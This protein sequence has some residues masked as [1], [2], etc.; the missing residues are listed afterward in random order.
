MRIGVT[1]MMTDTAARTIGPG[2]LAA[3]V[4]G[5]GFDGLYLPEHTH[6][7]VSRATPAPMGEPLP[8]AYWHTLDPF[9]ALTAAAAATSTIRLGTGVCLIAERDPIITAKTVAS[10]DLISGGRV[11]LGI[12]FGWNVEEMADHGV[13]FRDRRQVTRERMLAMRRLWEDDE[14]AFDGDHVSIAPSWAWPK[15]TQSTVPV[16]LGVGIGP[17]NLA[18]LV[19]YCQGWI[20]IGG[21]GLRDDIPRVTAALEEAG[22][23]PAGFDIV[24]FGSTP[25]ASKLDYFQGVGCTQ[26]VMNAPSAARDDIMPWLEHAAGVVREFRG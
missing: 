17:K 20:P 10:L 8:D 12:G 4:E 5:L 14:A 18:H 7:P 3:T 25:D 1:T 26:V 13:A 19:E 9:V 11:D 24:P 21:S 22:R 2:E 15:P 16:W 6:I 23:D